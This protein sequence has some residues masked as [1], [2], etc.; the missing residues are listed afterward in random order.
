IAGYDARLTW[1]GTDR[2]PYNHDV[3]S[4]AVDNHMICSVLLNGKIYILDA[5]EKYNPF[6]TYAERIQGKEILIEDGAYYILQHVPVEPLDKY[7]QES[8]VN[9]TIDGSQ[10]KGEG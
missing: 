10:L 4:L 5:T 6:G 1:I 3:P 7:L 8:F 2:I 9:Y